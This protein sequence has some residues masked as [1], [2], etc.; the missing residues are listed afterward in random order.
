MDELT[1]LALVGTANL[2]ADAASIAAIDALLPE[3]TREQRLLW[4]AGAQA[5]YRQAGLQTQPIMLPPAAPVE[6]QQQVPAALHPLLGDL[7]AG[8]LDELLPWATAHFAARHYHLPAVLLPMALRLNNK[9]SRQRWLPLL[10]ERGRWLAAQNA[11]WH[12]AIQPQQAPADDALL[13]AHWHEGTFAVRRRALAQTRQ[14]DPALARDWLAAALPQEKA[15]QRL[16]LAE[17]LADGLCNDDEALLSSLLADRSQAVRQLAAGLLAQLP[18]SA[19]ALRMSERAH[20]TLQWAQPET[21]GAFAKVASWLGKGNAPQLVVDPPLELPRD[22]EK[23]GIVANPSAGEGKRAWWL[24]QL[25]ALVPPSRWGQLTGATPATLLPVLQRSDWAEALL[26][27]LAEASCR[28]ADADWA[29]VLVEQSLLAPGGSMADYGARL[30]QT[31]AVADQQAV[32]LRLLG[33]DQLDIVVAVL[34]RQ[35]GPWP[36][37]VQQAVETMLAARQFA[38]HAPGKIEPCLTLTALLMLQISDARLA[39]LIAVLER[40]VAAFADRQEW[41]YRHLTDRA[42]RIVALAHTRQTIIQETA[43]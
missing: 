37:A 23:D 4:Q 43:P 33:A 26:S 29:A 30:W 17:V 35:D 40:N 18:E 22:W 21:Q 19:F 3:A 11:D 9:A 12:W 28:F 2:P 24:R 6:L 14:R 16:A 1:R 41:I 5:V 7:L 20:A 25:L 42:A 13:A 10:G 36:A 31:L 8:Q 39:A 38:D 32:L 34:S 27:G 15:E